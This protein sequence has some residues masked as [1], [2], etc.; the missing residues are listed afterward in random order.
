[1]SSLGPSERLPGRGSIGSPAAL[2]VQVR[3]RAVGKNPAFVVGV[4]VLCVLI[5][6]LLADWQ[7]T[8]IAGTKGS[9]PLQL[10]ITVWAGTRLARLWARAEPRPF[11]IIFWLY[12]Y[13]WLGLSGLVQMISGTTP[14]LIPTS[15]TAVWQGQVIVLVGLSFLELGHLFS[16]PTKEVYGSGRQIIDSRVTILVLVAL[17][18]APIWY[19]I[20]GGIHTLFSSRQELASSIFGRGA[21]SSLANG[22]IKSV[23]STVPIFLALYAVIVTRKHRLSHRNSRVILGSP[24]V[25]ALLIVATFILN[26]PISMPRQWIA[27]I[28]IAL[29][30]A[31]PSV[32]KK[33]S[34]TR[35]VIVGA[36]LVS[37]ALFPYAA[38]FRFSSGFKRPPGV[39]Q[40][41]ETKGDYDSFQMITAGVQYTFKEGFRYG[42]QALG[43]ALFFVPRSVWHSK[44]ED[45]GALIGSHFQLA[46]TNLSAPLWIEG[47]IDFGYIGLVA[48]FLL[49]GLLMRRADDR[50]VKGNSPFAQFMIPLLAGYTGIL[51]RGPLLASMGRL[52]VMLVIAWL[53]SERAGATESDGLLFRDK[54]A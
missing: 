35:L 12:V 46:F 37:I 18:T 38:Y 25:L 3:T 43:D 26:S 28:I 9:I 8:G 7:I 49:Y 30:F 29:I 1:M 16:L 27:T 52:V 2:G 17:I 54:S 19:Q 4:L 48:I 50:F 40:T 22:G 21:T 24:V 23:F 32:Q 13:V 45:T 39:V 36:V 15:S 14:W 53:I 44:A 51:L 34:A 47:Y 10:L 41:L 6:G 42:G 33:P 5:P 11:A 20:V 31:I